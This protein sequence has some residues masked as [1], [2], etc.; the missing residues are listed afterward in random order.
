M[1]EKTKEPIP[2][3]VINHNEDQRTE[4]FML[5]EG[6]KMAW[7]SST[8]YDRYMS[9]P[10]LVFKKEGFGTEIN[11]HYVNDFEAWQWIDMM[12]Q[13]GVKYLD[14]NP[15]FNIM[16]YRKETI[17]KREKYKEMKHVSIF[18]NKKVD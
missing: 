13:L 14:E 3:V 4:I 15:D 6:D 18:K 1:K 5:D 11:E 9:G 17:Q 7:N 12:M 2:L 16:K 10:S 8:N